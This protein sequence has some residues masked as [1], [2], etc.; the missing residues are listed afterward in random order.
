MPA[1]CVFAT[2]PQM[3]ADYVAGVPRNAFQY[4]SALDTFKRQ[5]AHLEAGGREVLQGG[6]ATACVCTL[7]V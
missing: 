6:R 2:P 1:V 7:P 4:P 3:L 5:F